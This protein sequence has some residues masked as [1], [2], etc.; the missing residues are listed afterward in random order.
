MNKSILDNVSRAS[1][2]S[3][4][5]VEYAAGA[6][7]NLASFLTDRDHMDA[8]NDLETLMEFLDS[9]DYAAHKIDWE[10]TVAKRALEKESN[11]TE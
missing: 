2:L 6:K 5:I 8:Y 3:N 1:S 4:S 11:A 7:E 9:I 10:A